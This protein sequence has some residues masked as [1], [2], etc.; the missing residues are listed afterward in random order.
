MASSSRKRQKKLEKTRKKRELLKK[1][2]RK[3]EAQFQGVSL[4]RLA[5]AAPFGPAWLSASL[6]ALDDEE[7]PALITVIVTRRVRG[8]LLAEYVLVDRTCLG[9]K[10]ATLMPPLSELDLL[11]RVDHMSRSA[12]PLRE[13][14]PLEAQSVVFHALDYARSLGFFAHEDFELALFEPRPES[15]LATPLAQPAQPVYVSGPN[16]DVP[17]ILNHLSERV[18]PGNFQ[19]LAGNGDLGLW[20]DDSDDAQDDESEADVLETSGE[21]SGDWSE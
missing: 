13:C 14:Q 11:E 2:V 17:M 1:E 16:D 18:G 21:S 8:L 9:V 12:D 15:L 6:D 3:R 20:D 10:N 7:M 19:F 5:Q 4:L